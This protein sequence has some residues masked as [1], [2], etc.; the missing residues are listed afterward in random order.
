MN[1]KIVALAK[2]IEEQ[3]RAR[4]AA[5]WAREVP[6]DLLKL[7]ASVRIIAGPKYTKV[8]VGQSGKYMVVNETGAIHG[9]KAYGVIHKGHKYGTLDTI[10]D[11]YWGGYRPVEIVNDDRARTVLSRL[12]GSKVCPPKKD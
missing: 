5:D 3:T 9:I 10:N 12:V 2:L 4:F 7:N 6:E 11:F 8:D 1:P